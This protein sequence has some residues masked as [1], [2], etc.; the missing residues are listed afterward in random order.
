MIHDLVSFDGKR[1]VTAGFRLFI[2]CFVLVLSGMLAGC[3]TDDGGSDDDTPSGVW[4]LISVYY[5]DYNG[6]DQL[7]IET[8]DNNAN[9]KVDTGDQAWYYEYDTSGLRSGYTMFE[10]GRTLG[11]PDGVGTYFYDG[12][13]CNNRLEEETAQGTNLQVWTYTVDSNC[14]RSSYSYDGNGTTEVGTYTRDA[15]NNITKL[16][17]D[18]GDYW[19]YTLGTNGDPTRYDFYHNGALYRYGEYVYVNGL[20][21]RLRNYEKR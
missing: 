10:D 4:T 3:N 13:D 2:L 11:D 7:T 20:L 6:D 19:E 1:G 16:K 12:N 17:L 8:D 18:N 14:I 15:N 21:D 9:N 5:Y